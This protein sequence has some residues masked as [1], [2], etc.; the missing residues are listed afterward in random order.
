[1]I[2]KFL[3]GEYGSNDE[4][5]PIFVAN[6]YAMDRYMYKKELFVDMES[7]DVILLDRY[8]FSNVAYQSAKTKTEEERDRIFQMFDFEFDFLELPY[9]NL[10]LFF[11]VPIEEIERRLNSERTGEDREY[12]DGKQDI[13]EK[14]IEY[15]RKV[16]DVYIDMKD[17]PNFFVIDAYNEQGIL[18]PTELFGSYKHLTINI[19]PQVGTN[20]RIT[21]IT[22]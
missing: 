9:P 18:S 16:R 6:I 4:V 3:K 8:S 13:H 22:N 15:Q 19:P 2:T 20:N 21:K 5:D 11:D 14:D 10:V 17:F 12:L 1:M 7:N